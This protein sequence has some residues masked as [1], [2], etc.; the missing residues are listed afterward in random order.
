MEVENAKSNARAVLNYANKLLENS[1]NISKYNNYEK[2][3]VFDCDAPDDILDVIREAEQSENNCILL[4]SSLLFEDWLLMH[5]EEI[6]EGE[7]RK[8]KIAA[9]LT[10]H[11]DLD[12]YE[13]HKNDKGIIAKILVGNQNVEKAILNA[14]I[15]R[16]QYKEKGYDIRHI[17][18][19]HL[20]YS[21]VDILVEQLAKAASHY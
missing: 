19:K 21:K 14:K 4:V 12:D 13:K 11:L 20:H 1:E 6:E 10:S 17:I 8:T 5:L 2:Y 3:L 16:S 15:L 9:K 18:E 7:L